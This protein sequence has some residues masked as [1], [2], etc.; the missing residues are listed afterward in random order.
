LGNA[1]KKIET[2]AI[3]ESKGH[4]LQFPEPLQAKMEAAFHADF[5]SVRMTE[6]PAVGKA[7]AQAVTQGNRIHFAPGR[8]NPA[9]VAGQELIGH[10]LSHVVTQ[11][12]GL[13]SGAGG[14]LYDSSLESRADREGA[15][16]AR[17][18]NVSGGAPV[19]VMPMSAG[20]APMQGKLSF[21]KPKISGP[22]GFRQKSQEEITADILATNPNSVYNP[23]FQQRIID[24]FVRNGNAMM[25]K[26]QE[27]KQGISDEKMRLA[28]FMN[29]RL[30]PAFIM[31]FAALLRAVAPTLGAE[32]AT[33]RMDTEEILPQEG[34]EESAA[35]ERRA[36]QLAGNTTRA[37]ED[38]AVSI[39]NNDKI[40]SVLQAIRPM[41]DGID[42]FSRH[43]D[44]IT[45]FATN[46]VLLRCINPQMTDANNPEIQRAGGETS[47]LAQQLKEESIFLQ[48]IGNGTVDSIKTTAR[49]K[50]AFAQMGDDPLAPLRRAVANIMLETGQA[51]PDTLWETARQ[52]Q[53][54][55]GTNEQ[56][57]AAYDAIAA[58]QLARLSEEQRSAGEEYITDSRNIN[59]TLRGTREHD[60]YTDE[61]IR[62]L[63]E[64]MEPIQTP[65][66][67]YRT[68]PDDGFAAMLS[69][70]GAPN[71]LNSDGSLNQDEL[72]SSRGSLIGKAF[73][74]AGFVST[75]M[76]ESFADSWGQG[77]P[78]RSKSSNKFKALRQAIGDKLREYPDYEQFLN[79][80]EYPEVMKQPVMHQA[81]QEILGYAETERIE[82][83]ID[84]VNLSYHML[85]INLPVGTPALFVD[86]TMPS[87]KLDSKYRTSGRQY[88]ILLKN[89]CRFVVRG[90][91]PYT[92]GPSGRVGGSWKLILDVVP[93]G[94]VPRV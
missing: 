72:L 36:A 25:R 27:E 38:I 32:T 16:A 94:G 29:F 22:T 59:N 12:K 93:T 65:M 45:D 55:G 10:E 11:A 30:S 14:F 13:T 18:R 51:E 88:E 47:R 44:D 48:R 60:E 21:K 85:Q 84:S 68:V 7:G 64:A 41:F 40:A 62:L 58:A 9:S 23:D 56:M 50:A 89:G 92:S 75:T 80:P 46:L 79:N 54:P 67:A 20:A 33:A 74:D 15:M 34:E 24:E 86:G 91:E 52:A 49:E 61:R 78:E 35:E 1:K 83:E 26:T 71:L 2:T 73:L 3:P 17:S 76:S 8:F 6:N 66:K 81:A 28:L 31:N 69:Q 5:R 37:I 63:Q 77:L 43:P 19:S 90:I 70:L 82:S 4:A 87:Q 39:A 42:Y 57:A 53:R